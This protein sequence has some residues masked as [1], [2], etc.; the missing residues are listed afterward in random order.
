MKRNSIL[1]RGNRLIYLLDSR[2]ERENTSEEQ[3]GENR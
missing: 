3:K 1:R 2:T